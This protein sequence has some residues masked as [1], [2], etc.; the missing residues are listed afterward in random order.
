MSHRLSVP[1]AV[2]ITGLVSGLLGAAALALPS[3]ATAARS[4]CRLVGPDGPVSHVVYIQFDN[5]HFRR[6]N[7]NVPSDLEQMP[8]LLNFLEHGTLLANHHDPLLSHTADDLVTSLIGLY[9]DRHGMPI[10]NEYQVYRP[11]GRTSTAGSFGYWTDPVEF[12]ITELSRRRDALGA[13]M[14]DLLDGAAFRNERIDPREARE[15]ERQGEE[16][17]DAARALANG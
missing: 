3:A 1:R 5:V 12:A 7:P 9:G 8:H 14:I 11:N 13:Q 17:I 10:A 6:D 2:R 15:L 4:T 16:L